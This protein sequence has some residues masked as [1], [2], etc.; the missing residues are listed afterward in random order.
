LLSSINVP[1]MKKAVNQKKIAT[2][3][4]LGS[5]DVRV[6]S[7]RLVVRTLSQGFCMA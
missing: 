5:F 7:Y 3:M 4:V 2:Q 1:N 6:Y